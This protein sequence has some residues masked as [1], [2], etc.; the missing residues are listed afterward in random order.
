MDIAAA[1]VESIYQMSCLVIVPLSR[2]WVL[3]KSNME[4][5]EQYSL[6]KNC[7][8]T[9]SIY[10]TYS[11]MAFRNLGIPYQYHSWRK[12]IMIHKCLGI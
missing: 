7:K 10:V 6:L 11:S 3:T 9:C 2:D 8:S 5:L 1:H 4:E 12:M